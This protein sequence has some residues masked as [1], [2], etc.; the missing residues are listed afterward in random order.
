VYLEIDETIL[1][2]VVSSWGF[3]IFLP[4]FKMQRQ[5]SPAMKKKK[6]KPSTRSRG[7]GQCEMFLIT[8]TRRDSFSL[9]M[10][11]TAFNN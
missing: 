6:K 11:I 9:L 10:L 3:F 8:L 7:H 4:I 1:K 2:S 5:P